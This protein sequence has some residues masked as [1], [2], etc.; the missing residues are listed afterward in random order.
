MPSTLPLATLIAT[1]G[2]SGRLVGVGAQCRL[3]EVL[4]PA[5]IVVF[6]EAGDGAHRRSQT[7]VGAFHGLIRGP[8]MPDSKRAAKA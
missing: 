8:G 4:E 6:E 7:V 5:G 2:L 1:T 3:H